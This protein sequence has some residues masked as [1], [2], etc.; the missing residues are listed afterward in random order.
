[1]PLLLLLLALPLAVSAQQR[2]LLTEEAMTVKPGVA[3]LQIGFEFLQ[4]ARFPL[5]GLEGDLSRVGVVDVRFGVSRAAEIQIQGTIRNYLSVSEQRTAFVTPV[6]SRGGTSTSDFGDFTIAAKFRLA[7]ETETRP[8]FGVRF[9]FEMPNSN[10][11][12]G[13]GLNTTNIFLTVLAQ[14]H[15]GKLNLFGN[16]GYAILQAPAGLF[17]QNDVILYGVGA[18]YPVHERVNLLGEVSGR[19]STR[20]TPVTSALVATGSRSQARLGLQVFAGG[21]R[22]DF[23]GLAGLT[24]DDPDSGFAFGVSKS[25]QLT[26]L[27]SG[28]E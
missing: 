15:F 7:D 28:R 17:T 9:G 2:P 18:L 14:K 6:L 21:L 12:R 10:E 26:P 27:Y 25:V 20:D 24:K 5:A 16:L 4:D 8:A 1:M 23:A 3:L 22:W 11:A 19:Y 13:I